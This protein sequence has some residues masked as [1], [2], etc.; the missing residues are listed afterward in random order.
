VS[1]LCGIFGMHGEID[2]PLIMK[3]SEALKHRGPDDCGFF[4]D[5]ET[6]LGN[7]RLSIIDIKGGHQPIH[8]EDSTVWIVFNGEIYNFQELRSALD[9]L[10]HTFYT[11]SDTEVIVHAYEQWGENCVKELNGM[12]AFAIWDAN[13]KTLFLSRDRLGIKPLYYFSND[14]GF[15]FASEIKAIILNKL[16]P[17]L[18]N[19]PMIYE[20]LVYGL[21][22]HT[23]QTFFSQI[24][25]LLPAHNLVVDRKGIYVKKYWNIQLINKEVEK[26]NRDDDLYAKEFLRLF[27]DSVR[28]QLIS[29]VPIGTC[30]SGGLDSSSI[31]CMV[32]NLL[33]LNAD[34]IRV[35]GERQ[36][37]FTVCFRDKQIDERKYVEYLTAQTTAEK[38]FVYP[39]SE[40][41]WKDIEKLVYLQEE[42]FMSASVY[43]QWSVMK[44]ASQK[45]KVVLDGQGGDELLAGYEPYFAILV[46]ELWKKRKIHTFIK[47][48]L[49]G[50]DMIARYVKQNFLSLRPKQSDKLEKLL[51]EEFKSEFSSWKVTTPRPGDLVALLCQE[52]TKTSLPRLL[53][54]E[55]KNSMSFSLEARVPF[56]DH[57]LVEYMFSIPITQRL[58]NGWTKHILRN[59]M[60]GILP[61]KIRKRRKKIGFAIPEAAWMKELRREIREVFAS[62]RFGERRYFNQGEVLKEFDEFCLMKSSGDAN[63]F[64]RILNLEIWLRVFVDK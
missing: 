52:V 15:I 36:K 60:K 63:L 61:E 5:N 14:K 56:L 58:K 42:P 51:S 9:K 10:G 62:P 34:V 32:N 39:S 40:Q 38:N 21:H 47:E 43:A 23:E 46:Q 3:M 33:T 44:L 13:R 11:D 17:K 37:T 24:K 50:L 26:S 4:F 22:D 12:W 45:V 6:A 18:P 49:L 25:R 19:D 2:K 29:E 16:V 20:Y 59:A 64:W 53:R 7:T 30:L 8:N 28:L 57:R 54:Y 35:V 55:D 27:K 48:L 31:V 1:D 41:L